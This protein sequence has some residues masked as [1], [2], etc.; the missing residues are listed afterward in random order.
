MDFLGRSD[1]FL[2][3]LLARNSLSS[4][5]DFVERKN[6]DALRL[7]RAHRTVLKRGVGDKDVSMKLEHLSPGFCI[8]K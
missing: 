2:S 5:S 4:I 6:F 1:C 8:I 3:I 7:L